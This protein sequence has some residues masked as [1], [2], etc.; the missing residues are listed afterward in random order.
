MTASRQT[1]VC[2]ACVQ[3]VYALCPAIFGPERPAYD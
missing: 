3:G 1:N 2:T